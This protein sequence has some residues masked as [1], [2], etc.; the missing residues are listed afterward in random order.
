MCTYFISVMDNTKI[1]EQ[2]GLIFLLS[3][4]KLDTFL[5]LICMEFLTQWVEVLCTHGRDNK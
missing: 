4:L 3:V 5:T 2:N 1:N